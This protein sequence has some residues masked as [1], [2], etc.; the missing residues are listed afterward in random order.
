MIATVPFIIATI[1]FYICSTELMNLLGKCLVCYLTCLLIYYIPLS[2]AYS[3]TEE[4]VKPI[5]C[6]LFAYATYFG[7]ISGLLWLNVISFDLWLSFR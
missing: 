7:Y 3:K 1:L 6:T 2:Y 4:I 5:N